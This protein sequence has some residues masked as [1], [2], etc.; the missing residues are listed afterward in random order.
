MCL[1]EREKET[2]KKKT[3][4]K[5]N[6]CPLCGYYKFGTHREYY[7]VNVFEDGVF[8]KITAKPADDEIDDMYCDSCGVEVNI[9]KSEEQKKVVLQ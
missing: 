3:V 5:D 1:R 4:N 6:V 2:M 9:E 7:Q 8:H